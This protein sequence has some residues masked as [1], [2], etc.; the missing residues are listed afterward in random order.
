MRILVVG[1]KKSGVYASILAKQRGSDVFLTEYSLNEEIEEMEGLLKKE[2]VPYEVGGHSYDKFYNFDLAVLSPGV[3]LNS[4]VVKALEERHI[5]YVGELEFAFRYSPPKTRVIAITGTNGKST[6]TALVGHIL[7]TAH[8]DVVTGGNLGTPYSALLLAHP[9]PAYAVLEISCFQLETIDRFH[10]HIAVFLNFTEDHLDRYRNVEEYLH[11]K[12][13]IF[14]NQKKSDYAVL[15]IDDDTVRGFSSELEQEVYFFSTKG[16]L[17]KGA[18]YKNG[19]IYFSDG[20]S[21]KILDRDLIP[22]R[23]MHN[24]ENVLSAVVASYLAGVKFEDIKDGITT[25]EGLPHRLEYVRT[26]SDV[27][28]VN[29]SKSTTPDSTIKALE[30]FNGRVVLIAGG[31]SKNSDFANLAKLFPS[32]LKALVL[33]GET[34]PELARAAISN[35]FEK[36][37]FATSLEEAVFIARGEAEGGDVVLLSPACASFDMFRDFEERGEEFK[38]IVEGL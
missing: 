19:A 6:T 36:Y 33:I 28:Y 9:E 30:S 18:Y 25:F 35:G 20:N 3:P 16:S 12:K 34:A 1:A 32:K 14:E 11:Y 23:G 24:V 37:F 27:I 38:R 7:E 8:M 4:P 2:G 31:S 13:R 21:F 29:D 15:N 10:P 22:L 17:K 26:L 5:P